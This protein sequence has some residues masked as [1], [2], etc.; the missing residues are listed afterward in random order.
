MSPHRL[1]HAGID[2]PHTTQ[3]PA[4]DGQFED[5]SHHEVHHQQRVH[6]RL[7]G[8]H[9]RHIL[10]HLIGSQE[11][12]RQGEDQQV[13]KRCPQHEHQVA[14]CAEQCGVFLFIVIERWCH[15]A[16]EHIYNIR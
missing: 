9:V 16:E 6:I 13:V 12:Q 10:A 7:Q 5:N 14:A 2:Q 11:L 1:H 15:K 4:D 3:E 8:Q